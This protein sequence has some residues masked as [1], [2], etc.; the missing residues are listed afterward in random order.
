MYVRISLSNTITTDGRQY[1]NRL[2][3]YFK[4]A[5]LPLPSDTYILIEL[6]GI[7]IDD[8]V[9]AWCCTYTVQ[10][11]LCRHVLYKVQQAYSL[12]MQACIMRLEVIL[13]LSHMPHYHV[14][15]EATP[16]QLHI[17]ACCTIRVELDLNWYDWLPPR[18]HFSN[19]H[20]SIKTWWLKRGRVQQGVNVQTYIFKESA[21]ILKCFY[22]M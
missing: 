15:F 14:L 13:Q 7:G 12:G 8:V 22:L 2:G 10:R 17:Q 11:S 16:S 5:P 21:P 18:G 4:I 9:S 19:I 6:R 20:A 1:Q 3:F